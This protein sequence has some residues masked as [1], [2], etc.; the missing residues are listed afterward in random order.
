MAGS[1]VRVGLPFPGSPTPPGSYERTAWA[2]SA[3]QMLIWRVSG[4]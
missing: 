4:M 3:S 2:F 1:T